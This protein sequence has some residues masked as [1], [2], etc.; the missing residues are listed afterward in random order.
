M[1]DAA[2]NKTTIMSNLRGLIKFRR[3]GDNVNEFLLAHYHGEFWHHL[4]A[5]SI[6]KKY[7]R[8]ELPKYLM[9]Y[10]MFKQELEVY[11]N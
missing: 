2:D 1:D 4:R 11:F 9:D 7:K 6:I 10:T 3:V 5:Q 8:K